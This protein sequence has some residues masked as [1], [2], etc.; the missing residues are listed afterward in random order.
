MSG[1]AT[2]TG[3]STTSIVAE[4]PAAASRST[5]FRDARVSPQTTEGREN[6]FVGH[7]QTRRRRGLAR[8]AGGAC[9]AVCCCIG[10]RRLSTICRR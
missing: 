7:G 1:A 3:A 8:N 4:A 6:G 2:H 10:D 9:R 5:S